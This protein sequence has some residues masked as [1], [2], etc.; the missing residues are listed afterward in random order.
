MGAPGL[1]VHPGLDAV[2]ARE[3]AT[4]DPAAEWAAA[5]PLSGG[6]GTVRRLTVTGR[7]FLL[8]R[9][10]RGGM[11]GRLLPDRYLRRE[12]FLREWALS[13]WLDERA[14]TPPLRARWFVPRGISFQVFTLLEP[15]PDAR[16][17][18]D[19]VR[20]GLHRPKDFRGAGACVARLHSKG[21]LHGDLNAGNLLL[22]TTG[23]VAIDWRHSS[24]EATLSPGARRA[25]LDRLARSLVKVAGR[26]RPLD[27]EAWRALAEGYGEGIGEADPW[28][29]EWS[30]S[31]GRVCPLRRGLW[32]FLG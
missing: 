30:E 3:V 17:L 1:L 23:I 16:S 15:L 12:P 26:D 22:A 31:A 18:A 7:T 25:N 13:L 28:L 4:L 32:A 6:R 21:V 29:E 10:S 24:R 27:Q 19:L 5:E 9:E 2:V 14:L 11:S 8:K 20:D